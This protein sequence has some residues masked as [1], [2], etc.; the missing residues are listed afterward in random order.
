[1]SNPDIPTRRAPSVLAWHLNLLPALTAGFVAIGLGQAQTFQDDFDDGN[2]DGWDRFD[3]TEFLNGQGAPG[4]WAEYSFPDDG[5]GG[6]AYRIHALAHPVNISNDLAPRSFPNRPETYTRFRVAA[7]VLDWNTGTDIALGVVGRA[8]TIDVGTTDGYLFNLNPWDQDMDITLVAGEAP[9]AYI[10]SAAAPFTPARGPYRL[11]LLGSDDALVGHVY[12]LRDARAPVASTAAINQ[13]Y[14]SGQSGVLA[15]DDNGYEDWNGGDVTYD[16]FLAEE[17]AAGVSLQIVLLEPTHLGTART[18]PAPIRVSLFRLDYSVDIVQG[19]ITLAIDGV[20]VPNSALTIADREIW[21]NDRLSTLEDGLTVSYTPSTPPTTVEGWHT[22]SITFQDSNGKTVTQDWVYR[23]AV[24]PVAAALPSESGVDPGFDVRVVQSVNDQPTE[25][26]LWRAEE[27]LAQPPV[28]PVDVEATETTSVIN[29]TSKPVPNTEKD[30]LFDDFARFPGLLAN[31]D[32]NF[33][34]NDMA[35]E[36]LF[37]LEL[38]EG[39]HELGITSDDGF[40]LL[41]GSSASDPD[42]VL[43][44]EKTEST[45]DGFFHVSV[46]QDGVYPFRMVWFQ[47]G[48]GA[49]IELYAREAGATDPVLINDDSS[50]IQAYRS[51]TVPSLVLESAAL[52]TDT[53]IEETGATIDEGARQITVEAQGSTRYYRLRGSSATTIGTI[54]VQGTTVTMTY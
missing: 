33:N 48:G 35:M 54:E 43:I 45:F 2:D 51:V 5:H 30:G 39:T 52:L 36:A 1:M 13:D 7:D 31:D 38:T 15:F 21:F 27:Q 40:Q 44:A 50:P 4:E 10:G 17:L 9:V 20:T 49:H 23:Y 12:E 53:F 37:Y 32:P 41:C 8:A 26:S 25:N 18:L 19:S 42:T 46:P 24:L 47:R 34:A 3:L 6:K 14:A 29:Y 28:M 22:N 11:E 16:N